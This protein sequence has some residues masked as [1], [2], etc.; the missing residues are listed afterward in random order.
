[1]N[2]STL[3]SSKGEGNCVIFRKIDQTGVIV[4][5]ISQ[6]QKDKYNIFF[7]SNSQ[8]LNKY[9]IKGGLLVRRKEPSERKSENKRG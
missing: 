6:I 8:D 2:N 1:M 7:H 5:E 9:D 3:F 4:N